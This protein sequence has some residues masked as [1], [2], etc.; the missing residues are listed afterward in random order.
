MEHIKKFN[1]AEDPLNSNNI[2]I[3]SAEVISDVA[4]LKA[5]I[6]IEFKKQ[7]CIIVGDN[8]VGKSTLLETIR[9]HY[10]PSFNKSNYMVR[11]DMGK[12]IKIEDIGNKF[13]FT[14]IDFHGDDLKYS[15]DFVDDAME[16][17]IQQMKA[18]SGQVSISLLNHA[19]SDID[20]VKNGLVILDE[21]CRGQSIKNQWK[22]IN[23]IHSL[24][25]RY[26]CQF[27]ITTHSDTILGYF[28]NI[29]QYY[30]ISE[31]KDTTYKEFM[32]SQLS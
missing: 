8:G 13:N 16:L 20:Q 24:S 1:E 25:S 18:S 21:P 22:A 6:K 4:P 31:N 27:I 11:R 30:N 26:N 17:Q 5:G 3:K 2:Y 23:I 7:V 28:K 9:G 10:N 32:I 15:T 14:Y 29:A 19:L 12:H